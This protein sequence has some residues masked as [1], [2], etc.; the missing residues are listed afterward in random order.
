MAR[1][2]KAACQLLETHPAKIPQKKFPSGAFI[3][4][5]AIISG[6]HGDALSPVCGMV[7]KWYWVF[8]AKEN[9]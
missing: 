6:Y 7:V 5:Q 3:G 4:A 9:C 1:S 2:G 8:R